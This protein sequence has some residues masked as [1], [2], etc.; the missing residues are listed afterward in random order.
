[1]SKKLLVLSPH[2]DDEVIACG[3]TIAKLIKDGWEAFVVHLTNSNQAFY[4]TETREERVERAVKEA[5]L[6]GAVL[7][8]PKKNILF[9]GLEDMYLT[10]GGDLI[11]V[12]IKHI[13]RVSP[14]VVFTTWRDDFHVDHRVC[15]IAIREAA[16]QARQAVCGDLGEKVEEPLVLLGEV[17]LENRTNLTE[18]DY[19]FDIGDTIGTKVEALLKYDSLINEHELFGHNYLK[20]WCY[21]HAKYRGQSVGIDYAE[22]FKRGNLAPAPLE[23][24]LRD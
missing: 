18:P 23:K 8:V 2:T 7:G 15:G 20:D 3:G 17:D 4:S 14:D 24:L 12:F 10:P 13:R 1:M 6:A 11:R 22:V 5:F 16:Y 19:W 9:E 21:T